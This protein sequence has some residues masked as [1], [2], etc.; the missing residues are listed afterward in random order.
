M[1]GTSIDFF[2]SYATRDAAW[3]K[4]I[5][6]QLE[7]AGYSTWLQALDFRPGHN[8]V[9]QMAKGLDARH[10]LLVLTPTYL[11]RQMP[12]AEWTAAFASD[13]I[14][15]DRRLIP[16]LVEHCTLP[17]LLANRVYI[18]LR[19]TADD[20]DARRILL[21]GVLPGRAP[22]HS[23]APFPRAVG[24][25]SSRP[26]RGATTLITN[27]EGKE[28]TDRSAELRELRRV[29]APTAHH[30]PAQRRSVVVGVSGIGKSALASHYAASVSNALKISWRISG[31]SVLGLVQGLTE[32]ARALD[33]PEATEA[34]SSAVP[35]LFR[36]L[37]RNDHWLLVIDGVDTPQEL[38]PLLPSG[39]GT[40]VA[41]SQ[42]T[43]WDGWEV[44]QIGSL[45]ISDAVELLS[46]LAEDI[47]D[48]VGARALAAE[49]GGHPYALVAAAATCRES[50]MSFTTYLRELGVGR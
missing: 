27:I 25:S 22:R 28:L 32:L 31:E 48:P 36:W 4:W 33:L 34:S 49:L 3:A 12:T 38:F 15:V 24:S 42:T 19:E 41:T 23:D 40:I 9:S 45:A 29:A 44:I 37:Q 20:A 30:D 39:P 7:E 10:T 26:K 35:A 18:D 16:V 14:G 13:P 2:I 1:T 46:K 21:E 50:G 8:F 43:G 11:E 5:A 6:A 47:D 17:T